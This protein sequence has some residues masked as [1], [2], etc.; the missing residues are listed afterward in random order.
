MKMF[1]AFAS[2]SSGRVSFELCFG[3]VWFSSE[4]QLMSALRFSDEEAFEL[5]SRNLH[6]PLFVV[7]LAVSVVGLFAGGNLSRGVREDRDNPLHLPS[8][9]SRPACDYVRLGFG[10][11]LGSWAPA[12][13]RF[14]PS[15]R[16]T[17]PG[18]R[19]TA[20][21]GIWCGV[22]K[23]LRAHIPPDFRSLLDSDPFH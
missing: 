20:P 2:S 19:E 14:Y 15:T 13:I 4:P 17:D 8:E 11:S 3:S 7:L 22:Q 9:L 6:W 12:R 5:T 1:I 21:V 23:L 16:C 10:I 18:R